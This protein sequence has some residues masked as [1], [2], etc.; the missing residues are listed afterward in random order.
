[1][2]KIRIILIFLIIINILIMGYLIVSPGVKTFDYT[3]YAKE[4]YEKKMNI[5]NDTQIPVANK[6]VLENMDIIMKNYSG[7]VEAGYINQRIRNL[8][9]GELLEFYNKTKGLNVY[10]LSQYLEKN[11]QDIGNKLGITDINDFI[12]FVQKIQIYKNSNLVFEKA[13]VV[14]NSYQKATGE[15]TYDTFK[16]Q[17]NYTNGQTLLFNVLFSNYDHIDKPIFII[18]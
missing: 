13:Q 11:N 12:N 2:K 4:Q 8:T 3:S 17:L 9:Q 10:E 7:E 15:D 16:I 18:K 5:T 6:L 1:M 14:E